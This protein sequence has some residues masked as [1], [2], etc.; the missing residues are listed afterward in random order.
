MVKRVA[1]ISE[2]ASPIVAHGGADSGGQNVYVEQVALNLAY[3][4]IEVDIYTRRPSST[5]PQVVEWKRKG[6]RVI[7]VTAGPTTPLPKEELFPHMGEFCCNML[8][9]IQE[10]GLEY[11]I[12]H[13]NFWMSGLAA[14]Y[15][16]DMLGLPFVITFHALGKVRR[17]FFGEEDSW[18]DERMIF[19]QKIIESAEMVISLCPQDK[20]DLLNLYEI[21]PQKIRMLPCGFSPDFWKITQHKARSLLNF[22]QDQFILL[23]VGRMVPRKGV[24]N[25]VEA[26]ALLQE[27]NIH[28]KLV[29][30]GGDEEIADPECT[31]EIGRLIQLATARGVQDQ[32]LFAGR[33]NRS[34][35]KHFY[36]AADVLVTTPWY[37]PFGITPLEAMVCG[38]PV[39][40]SRVGGIKYTVQE[41]ETGLLV[42]PKNPQD[43]AQAILKLY[44]DPE[45]RKKFAEK[46]PIRA[47]QFGWDH[48]AASI[49]FLYEEVLSRPRLYRN[50]ESAQVHSAVSD[51][52]AAI[53]RTRGVIPSLELAVGK[54]RRC[55]ASG[56]K[57][58]LAGNG[59]SAAQCQHLSAELVGR[60]QQI[61][62]GLPAIALTADTAILTAWSNDFSFDDIF[63]RQIEA[64]GKPEDVFLCISTS[65]RS[66]NLISAIYECMEKNI[67]VVAIVGGDG[68]E[69]AHLADVTVIAPGDNPQ[70]IQE[71][72][73][74]L[75]HLLVE[76]LEQPSSSIET[77]PSLVEN[78]T[79][80]V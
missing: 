51:L 13:A 22:P 73:L 52:E 15:L 71:V 75:V 53:S 12:V 30:V 59:G 60:F 58:L 41:G 37:E 61:R 16:K 62:K 44:R 31:P 33:K 20:E 9:F 49:L 18:G 50:K 43:L 65:G 8:Q 78:L 1:L 6:V 38:I 21:S 3:L 42:Q 64:L 69:I 5:L 17:S 4:D 70:R 14:L 72:Q 10:Q 34:E 63:A 48:I 35:L 47:S 11:D 68:G 54:I 57:L 76:L 24:D 19:E 39:I 80:V 26:V 32:I 23:N 77:L 67:P 7:H 29:V 2:H 36:C 55:F 27:S 74:F 79:E 28:V 25:V 66:A 56:G 45:L 40:G 46:A